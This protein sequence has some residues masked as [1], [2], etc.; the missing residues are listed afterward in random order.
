MAELQ[1]ISASALY[2]SEAALQKRDRI[3][4]NTLSTCVDTNRAKDI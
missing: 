2:E 4:E 1:L 3:A